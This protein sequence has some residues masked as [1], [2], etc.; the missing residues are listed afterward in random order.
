MA[1]RDPKSPSRHPQLLPPTGQT[2][3]IPSFSIRDLL[4]THL[5]RYYRYNGSLTTPPCFQ[6]VLWS[7]FP[8]PVRISRAQVGPALG[9]PPLLANTPAALPLPLPAGAAPGKPLFHGGGRAGGAPAAG[10]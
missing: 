5:D 10:G 2:V 7:L 9:N 4:P 3:A 6:S 8:Q 1:G